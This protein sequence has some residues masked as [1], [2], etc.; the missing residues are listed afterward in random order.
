VGG[1][2]YASGAGHELAW[3]A[4]FPIPAPVALDDEHIIVDGS[5]AD[6]GLCTGT[7][8]APS[9]AAGYVCVY[10]YYSTNATNVVG[11]IW[12]SSDAAVGEKWGFQLA[13]DSVA[14]GYAVY[15]ANWAYTAP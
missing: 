11:Y 6:T 14:A 2:I 13:V 10:D 1:K 5:S 7:P 4:S 15:F 12:G 8:A 9:A 3:T